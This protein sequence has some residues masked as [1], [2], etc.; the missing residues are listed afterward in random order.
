MASDITRFILDVGGDAAK[1]ARFKVDPDSVLADYDLS[2]E[3]K[4]VLKS[5][6]ID[7]IR[8]LVPEEEGGG[9]VQVNI[10]E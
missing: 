1:A 6:D 8:R 7:A 5:G 2:D 9:N 10:W 4:E 3:H